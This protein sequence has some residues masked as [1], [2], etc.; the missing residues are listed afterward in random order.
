MPENRLGLDIQ[1]DS[2]RAV[3]IGGG[4]KPRVAAHAQVEVNGQ[5]GLALALNKVLEDLGGQTDVDRIPCSVS[6]GDANT[7][8]KNVVIPFSEAKK[9]RQVLPFELESLIP[10]KVE[11][12]IPDYHVIRKGDHTDCLAA[13]N[14]AFEVGGALEIMADAGL[15]ADILAPSGASKVLGYLAWV[16]PKEDGVFLDVERDR[17]LLGLFSGKELILLRNL[18]QN[19]EGN[20]KALAGQINLTIRAFTEK[21]NP[22]FNPKAIYCAGAGM[23]WENLQD[24]VQEQTGLPLKEVDLT[25]DIQLP[26]EGRVAG[27]WDSSAMDGA[28]ALAL[29]HPTESTGFNMRQGPFAVRRRWEQYKG[30][31][32]HVSILLA[33]LLAAFGVR[34]FAKKSV[35]EAKIASLKSQIEEVYQTAMEGRA[36]SGD[37]LAAMMSEM[38]ALSQAPI[39]PGAEGANVQVVD[40][41]KAIS[42]GIPP[43]LN[44]KITS[45]SVNPERVEINGE[46][47]AYESATEIKTGLERQPLFEDVSLQ[48]VTAGKDPGVWKFRIKAQVQKESGTNS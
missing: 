25:R 24:A 2:V 22:A 18:R 38:E 6:F 11:E 12:A 20:L 7:S 46:T 3:V 28:L 45:F 17:V 35:Q 37:P 32:I 43:A 8:F 26:M 14:T 4:L 1:S 27:N 31:V 30:W 29:Y 34:Y 41:L 5:G 15:N 21:N 23:H 16:Q 44:V 48:S 10:Y 36:S 9:I 13:V 39:F 47:D 42:D 19:F 40:V 33:V